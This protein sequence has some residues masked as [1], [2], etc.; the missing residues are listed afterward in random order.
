MMPSVYETV[1]KL[2]GPEGIHFPFCDSMRVIRKGFGE[3]EPAGQRY[4]CKEYEKRFDDL[5]DTIFTGHHQPFKVWILGLYFMGL[6]LSNKHIAKELDLDRNEIQQ[7][8]TQLCD[9]EVK[10][11]PVILQD[12]V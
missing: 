2:L 6:N 12:E 9:G 3:K 4:E 5:T 8:T 1:C 7:M 10:K 11:L